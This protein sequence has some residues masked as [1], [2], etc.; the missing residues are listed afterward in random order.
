MFRTIHLRKLLSS[1]ALTLGTG[2]LAG[3][4]S[5]NQGEIYTN[6]NQ[7]PLAPPGAVFGI[8]WTI[9]YIFMGISLYLIRIAPGRD[10]LAEKA[11]GIQLFLNLCWPLVFFGFNW[12]CVSVLV[13]ALLLIALILTMLLFYRTQ[14]A[15]FWWLVPYLLWCF[16][17]LYLN[18]GVCVLN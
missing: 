11:F 8:V 6:L 1:L 12:Y 5:G 15:A 18:I 16:F 17:A 3:F 4:L 7:P 9:L 10:M 14:P 13:L 2:L